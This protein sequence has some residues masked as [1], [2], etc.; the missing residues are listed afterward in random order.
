MTK[1]FFL[2]F[3]LFV[4]TL[5]A[6]NQKVS[7]IKIH[8]NNRIENQT[9]LSYLPIKNGDTAD[10]DALD[11]CLKVLFDTGYF[12]D[13]KVHRKDSVIFIEVE[14]NPII[15]K[16][17]YE[18]N[19]K[20]KDADFKKEIQLR[21]R[22]VL[23]YAKIQAAQ[24]RI[25]EIYRR[26]GRF[27]AKVDP[28]IIRLAENRV[29]LVFEIEEGPTT[30]IRKIN[31]VGNKNFKG[32]RLEKV[33][34]SKVW[35]WYRFFVNDDLYDP[36]RF[37][38]DQQEIKKFYNDN[39][40]PDMRLISSIAELSPDKTAYFLTF[41][42]DEG[43]KYNFGSVKIISDIKSI[44]VNSLQECVSFEK[45]DEYNAALIDKT[46]KKLTEELGT[47]GY[48]FINIEPEV[49]KNAEIGVADIEFSIKEGPRVYIDTIE[50]KGNDRTRDYVIRREI[51]IHEGDAYNSKKIKDAEQALKDLGYF[52]EVHVQPEEGSTIDKAKINV[53]L[54]EQ[55]TGELN[56]GLGYSTLEGPFTT[57]GIQ[58]RNFRGTGQT[59]HSNATLSKI[60]TGLELGIREPA[61]LDRDLEGSAKVFANQSKRSKS[62]KERIFGSGLGLDYALSE[63]WWQS[64]N[65]NIRS[66][67]VFGFN[68]DAS[69]IIRNQSHNALLS[70]VGQTIYFGKLNSR[71]D[72]TKGFV[73]SYSTEF[74]GVGGTVKYLQHVWAAK[75]YYPLFSDEVV[76]KVMGETGM[77]QRIGKPIR[78]V[79]SF[80]MGYDSFR[81]F[82][83]QGVGPRDKKTG[84]PLNGTRM[85]R[86]VVEIKFPS[87]LP[88]D[89]KINASVFHELGALW[90]PGERD[91]D[92]QDS[93]SMRA[94]A[95]G[96]VLWT[97]P[98]GPIG[99]SYSFPYRR[100]KYD[101]ARRFQLQ[102]SNIF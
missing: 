38:N 46:I 51:K 74:A 20:I 35:H 85:W 82:D 25:L 77:M 70:S 52:K 89:W 17:A 76:L 37:L 3:F 88:D 62:H 96:G 94:S 53:D 30:F 18:G 5:Y 22:E 4:C 28:K 45:G 98:F 50:I 93:Q 10:I 80:H 84:D 32:T 27:S 90:K 65:Y 16:I 81:G 92:T 91:R 58:E 44:N 12:H 21:P 15:N 71:R 72:P 40:Y 55:R 11:Q 41:T 31:F 79:D 78:V 57:L 54:E 67:K 97:S 102:F 6:N 24:Q 75:F 69:S 60:S 59:V 7:A 19:E 83:F 61:L 2:T 33:L 23:S 8:G 101:V 43:R 99:M 26:L 39:G 42:I 34:Q 68:S 48:A 73:L 86:N 56:V 87:G 100:Q 36:D 9:I 63:M 47:L 95:G 1:R 64:L 66:E 49:K 14:E 29:D 13:V